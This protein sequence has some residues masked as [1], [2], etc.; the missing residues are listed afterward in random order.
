MSSL[1]YVPPG[2]PVSNPLAIFWERAFSPG[3]IRGT[4]GSLHGTHQ[5][6]RESGL[7][8][9]LE[10]SFTPGSAIVGKTPGYL[11]SRYSI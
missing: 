5:K 7:E 9:R 8:R 11:F 1:S 2:I 4:S 10:V 3:E 6:E